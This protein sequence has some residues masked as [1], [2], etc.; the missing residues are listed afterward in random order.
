MVSLWFVSHF[1]SHRKESAGRDCG[2]PGWCARICGMNAN[3]KDWR[4]AATC[5]GHRNPWSQTPCDVVQRIRRRY[6]QRFKRADGWREYVA[7]IVGVAPSTVGAWRVGTMRPTPERA[8][9]LREIC[10]EL[11]RSGRAALHHPANA[12]V[13]DSGQGQHP[14]CAVG[15]G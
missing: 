13:A 5:V 6:R 15:A 9:K 4:W 1:V 3:T 7:A 14:D 10:R 8:K 2:C 11:G 12:G